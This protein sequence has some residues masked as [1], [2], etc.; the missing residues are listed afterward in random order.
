MTPMSTSH[1]YNGRYEFVRQ[2]ARGG[3][4]EV[5]LAKDLK[6]NRSVALKV[7]FPE[8]STDL[9]FVRRFRQEA[10]AAANLTHHNI[11]SIFDWGESETE[12][13]PTYFMVMEYVDGEP[14]SRYIK[15]RG[16]LT[17]LQAAK[18]SADIAA[19]LSYAHDHG[20]IHRDV[21]PGNVII[22]SDGE[23]K[24]TDFGIARAANSDQSLTQTGTVMGTATYFSPE[25]AQGE[26][27]DAR[28]DI[29]SLGVVMYEMVTGQPP[30]SGSNPIAI[31][32]KHVRESPAAPTDINP[33]V[34]E[35]FERI[36]MKAMAK[37]L[38]ERY[39]SARELR[40]DLMRYIQG[41]QVQA[42]P[43]DPVAV[44]METTDPTTIVSAVNDRTRAVP[45]QRA[46][47][48]KEDHEPP[49]SARAWWTVAIIL[50]VLALGIGGYLVGKQIT[51]AN[52]KVS[53]PNVVGRQVQVATSILKGA[54]F[55]STSKV[56]LST[57]SKGTVLGESPGPKTM[58]P[59]GA[60][61]ALSVSSGPVDMPQVVGMQ[62]SD[63]I[64]Q[65]SSMGFTQISTPYK[66]SN[67]PSGT[68]IQQDPPQGKAVFGQPVT[69]TVSSGP[70]PITIP[71]VA[72]MSQADAAN[73]LGQAR[74]NITTVTQPSTSVPTG[75]V[76]KTDPPGGTSIS[77]S[78]PVTIVVS[79]G[80]PGQTVPNVTGMTRGAATTAL[81]NAG[82]IVAY[83]TIPVAMPGENNIVQ[84]Q[85][86][87]QNSQAQSG[88]T[89]TVTVGVY[90]GATTTTSLPA[91]TPSSTTS[92][93][94]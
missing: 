58:Q 16:F 41:G 78:Q 60:T 59:K 74:L 33:A 26:G 63:A 11:V 9:S 76:I 39:S 90:S 64:T 87:N 66:A 13:V 79:S 84:S 94:Q 25:Q 2:I 93:T 31:A 17:G 43:Y 54:G 4:A 29:Y 14:L 55:K 75:N 34:P 88:S 71:D 5:Y 27:A 22:T 68:V 52:S 45:V 81:Q 40:E 7:L 57:Q 80:P 47:F 73:A 51:N 86:P 6:L 28:S 83:A 38:D 19:G 1:V 21:K 37:S 56:E 85:S 20:V 70:A 15:S 10:Q 69:L 32:T 92:T 8:L 91:G 67:S 82:F 46:Q 3:M 24:V 42:P 23:A 50:V 72:G 35:E 61:I 36:I 62:L 18:I 49:K 89:V 12:T 30:F 77:P 53:V 44:A 65:L 48:N